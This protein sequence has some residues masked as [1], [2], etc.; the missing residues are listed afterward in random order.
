MVL[1]GYYAYAVFDK[2]GEIMVMV[3]VMVTGG[4]VGLKGR[5]GGV[6]LCCENDVR[7]QPWPLIIS[8]GSGNK[9]GRQ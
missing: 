8:A 5:S 3:V 4:I 9:L 6:L 1:R 7:E 2:E